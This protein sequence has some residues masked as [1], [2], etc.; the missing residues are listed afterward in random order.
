MEAKIEVYVLWAV[1]QPCE[2]CLLP[3]AARRPYS[4][5]ELWLRTP[6]TLALLYTSHHSDRAPVE[7]LSGSNAIGES[8]RP[9][10]WEKFNARGRR[11]AP[12]L[13]QSELG[14]SS[15]PITPGLLC[16]QAGG[17]ELL[18]FSPVFCSLCWTHRRR[19]PSRNQ[20]GQYGRLEARH[21]LSHWTGHK[22]LHSR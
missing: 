16:A 22:G 13:S 7:R 11:I 21:S 17:Q 8:S 15:R 3:A 9:A 2:S 10:T 19:P 18:G 20:H 6:K 14:H 5:T 1:V 12:A 4:A